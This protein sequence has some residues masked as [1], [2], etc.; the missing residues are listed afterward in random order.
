MDCYFL[1]FNADRESVSTLQLWVDMKLFT[2]TQPFIVI[3]VIVN[4]DF[5]NLLNISTLQILNC[6]CNR[7]KPWVNTDESLI[8]KVE[9]QGRWKGFKSLILWSKV[10]TC[11][12]FNQLSLETYYIFFCD[13][14]GKIIK[15]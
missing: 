10:S 8:V 3:C 15:T 6:K 14:D 11:L 1:N 9:S 5:I 2:Q 13:V 7:Q 12:F 4:S